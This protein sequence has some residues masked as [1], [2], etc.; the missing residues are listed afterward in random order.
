MIARRRSAFVQKSG[1]D[2]TLPITITAH[3]Y[4][5]STPGKALIRVNARETGPAR[6]LHHFQRTG[7][8]PKPVAVAPEW[9]LPIYFT[10][11]MGTSTMCGIRF[12]LGGLKTVPPPSR[13][14]PDRSC[15]RRGLWAGP[16][17]S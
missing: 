10:G 2:P 12:E 13:R 17:W 5:L 6:I 11:G 7:A 8:S 15:T 4:E 1:A 16:A 14:R 9:I 3:Y